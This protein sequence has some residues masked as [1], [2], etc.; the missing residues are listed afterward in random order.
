[1]DIEKLSS[2]EIKIKNRQ[3]IY[4]YIRRNE[5]VSKQ[6]LVVALELSLPTVTQNLEYLKRTSLI[7]SS[8]KITNTGGRNATAFTYLKK[9]KMAIGIYITAHHMNGV[10]VDL[11][12][13]VELVIKKQAVFDL[14]SDSYLRELGELV[15]KI[16]EEAGIGEK[17]LLGVGISVSGLISDDGET[18]IYGRT[19]NFTGRSKEEICKYIPYPCRLVHDSY[20]A[21]YIETW[22]D[23]DVRNAF[24]ISLSNSVGGSFIVDHEIYAGDTQKGGEIGHMAVVPENGELC[25][26]GKYGCF[27][28]VCRAG[29]LDE[30]TNGNL[31]EFFHRLGAGDERAAALWDVYL[32]HLASAIYNIRILF[33]CKVILGGYVGAYIGDY[34]EDLYQRV[35]EKN[36]FEDKAEDYI[37]ACRYKKEAS[38]AG[39]AIFFVDEFLSDI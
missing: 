16:K 1:M 38:A 34:L 30:Y 14:N 17:E 23:P 27:D 26:C 9:A 7:D 33:D 37:F 6:D 13:D 24:Y 36:P 25:Y 32:D 18:V 28:T 8:K 39:A 5:S 2:N 3:R 29:K 10:A 22:K 21:G 15:E 31:E 19:L 20:A 11:S 12:G 4:D 35:D